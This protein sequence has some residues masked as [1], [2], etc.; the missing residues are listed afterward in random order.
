MTSPVE[1]H[2]QERTADTADLSTALRSG[3]DDKGEAYYCP[4]RRFREQKPRISPLRC[5]SVEMTRGR[6]ALPGTVVAERSQFS[7]TWVVGPFFQARTATAGLHY[8]APVEKHFQGRTA[9]TADLSTTLRSGRDDKGESGASG[10][11]GGRIE[12]VFITVE[13]HSQGRTA[14]TADLST[15]LRSGRDDKR[16]G[17]RFRQ[18]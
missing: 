9:D 6:A 4:Q 14:D 8:A 13:K 10:E 7:L 16:G 3:R 18:Q 5:A 12:A 15:T 17:R 11:C 2:F 1:K